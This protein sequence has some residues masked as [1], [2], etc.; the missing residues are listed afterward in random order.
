MLKTKLQE[1]T[2]KEFIIEIEY[3]KQVCV[4]NLKISIVDICQI[5]QLLNIPYYSENVK[6]V[7]IIVYKNIEDIVYVHITN[8]VLRIYI[9][10]FH[11]FIET[12]KI[13]SKSP[14]D[15]SYSYHNKIF[16]KN[17]IEFHTYNYAHIKFQLPPYFV[18]NIL[19]KFKN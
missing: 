14:I 9:N 5:L 18:E 8:V 12:L 4:I 13:I 6:S 16:H 19:T 7:S 15:L 17:F 3:D 11:E 1:S 2:Y 10:D